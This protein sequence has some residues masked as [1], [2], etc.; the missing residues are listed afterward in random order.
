MYF[1][2]GIVLVIKTATSRFEKLFLLI[3]RFI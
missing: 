3:L 1:E 2:R